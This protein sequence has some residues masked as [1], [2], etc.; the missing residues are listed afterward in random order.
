[1]IRF[2]FEPHPMFHKEVFFSSCPD[3]L[4]GYLK[5]MVG[6]P[7]LLQRSLHD[8]KTFIQ[9]YSVG[10]FRHHI[11]EKKFMKKSLDE[12]CLYNILEKKIQ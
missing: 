1:M 7:I 5:K 6:S 2:D 9:S 10:C 8:V 11:N 12:V 3:E 4:K